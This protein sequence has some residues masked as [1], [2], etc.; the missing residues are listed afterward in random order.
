M[1]HELGHVLHRDILISSV[2]AT[3]AA[4]ITLLA[5]FAF[6]SKA[7][8]RD[9]RNGGALS[10]IAMMILAPIA[11]LLMQVA[12]S[13]SREYRRRMRHRPSIQGRRTN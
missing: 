12:I 4:A 8:G 10:A 3:L 9:R 1:A 7:A 13:R 11:A 5:R 2:A 6:S